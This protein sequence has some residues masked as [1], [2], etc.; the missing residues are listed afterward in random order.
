M[1]MHT[2]R[3]RL[4]SFPDIDRVSTV[5]ILKRFSSGQRWR[6]IRDISGGYQAQQQKH[7]HW[8]TDGSCVHPESPC[9]RYSAFAIILDLASDDDDDDERKFWGRQCGVSTLVPPTLTRAAVGRTCGEQDILRAELSAIY[10]IMM[11][12]AFFIP[13]VVLL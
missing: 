9:T 4:F 5:A 6:L 12:P 11:G 7:I 10:H 1:I 8:C 2:Q 13:I 3:F